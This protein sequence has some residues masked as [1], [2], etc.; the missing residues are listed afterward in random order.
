MTAPRLEPR[1]LLYLGSIQV[2]AVKGIGPKS[3]KRLADDGI[4]SVADL[5]MT[6]PRRYL[7]R[8]QMVPIAGAP[9]GED[10]TVLGTVTAFSKRRLRARRT[11]VDARIED[12][13]GSL[14]IVSFNPYL[15]LEVG[16]EVAASGKIEMYRG[17][18]QMNT[19]AIDRLAR[20]SSR[21]TGRVVPVYGSFG[22]LRSAK[23]REAVENAV[24]RSI[25]VEEPL[26]E[27][28]L[29]RLDLIDRSTAI[30]SL[31][32][33]ESLSEVDAAKRRLAFDEFL[34]IQMALKA[35][36]HD[37]YETRI[38]V[39]NS[40]RGP[41]YERY[42]AALPFSLT[43]D[44]RSALDAIL[45]DMAKEIP[46]H[47][48]L[49]G[50]VGSGKT[51]VVI[52]ALLT[53]VESGHQG[54]VM[55]PTEV[56]ATQHYLAT[57]QAL[58][59]AGMA[60]D[61]FGDQAGTGSLFDTPSLVSRP[62]RIGLFTSSRVSVNFRA[63]DVS[64]QQGLEWLADGTIDIAFGT[65]ALIQDD[66]VFRSLGI[67]VVDEQHRFGVEQ[68]V[69]LRDRSS[70][71]GVPDLLLMTA[72]PI[73]RTF[74]M[75]LYG[76]L[77]VS[78]I[79]TLP[80]GRSPIATSAIDALDDAEGKVDAMIAAE[81]AKG[82]QVFVVCPLV[83]DSDKIEARSAASEFGR[84]SKSVDA[85]VGLLHGQMA[86]PEKAEVMGRFRAGDIDVLVATTVIEVGIDVPNATLMVVWN[87]ERFGLS[88]L[89]QLRGRVGRGKIPGRCVLVADD[90]TVEGTLRVDAMVRTNDGFELAEVDLAI[91]GHGTIFGAAQSGVGD[92]RFGDL[93]RRDHKAL[94]EAASA[95][96]T[97]LVRMNR[98]SDV[99]RTY[100]DEFA[101]FV[102]D[103]EEWLAKS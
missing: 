46:L 28:T 7:D 80:P 15:T 60:P 67:T 17:K 57:R 62:V 16:E 31:H 9:F 22:G 81:V 71:E 11:M 13:T 5:L 47:R 55:A 92:L 4:R 69:N 65:H 32:G 42:L 94:V 102:G 10:I 18:R 68:R 49:Q 86:S 24:R 101:M 78:T 82:Q 44:Q 48:L 29:D 83:D 98:F 38:G 91:R 51:V 66:V 43:E 52:L 84:L 53:S 77:D 34:R 87:A 36:A 75:A 39:S 40:I 96:A 58:A 85:R 25:P 74:V 54:A 35:R 89:H 19:P 56:L 95:H 99:V 23:I 61:V 79:E 59:D 12:A 100:T 90:P 30:R 103:R 37:D 20:V 14:D 50:E 26:D 97:E 64:R 2:D 88:Q 6:A 73:P 3:L 63:D 72:T 27:P 33:P 76:D 45:E 8:S 1:T 41:L 93:T 21:Q 70:D